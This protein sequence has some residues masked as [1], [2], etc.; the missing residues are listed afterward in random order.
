MD[1]QSLIY[2]EPEERLYFFLQLLEVVQKRLRMAWSR[3]DSAKK[4]EAEKVKGLK[5]QKSL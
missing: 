1:A 4:A 3:R 2:P 5:L